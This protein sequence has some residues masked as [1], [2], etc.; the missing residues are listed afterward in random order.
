MNKK[1]TCLLHVETL[2]RID[3]GREGWENWNRN[4]ANYIAGGKKGGKL[5]GTRGN[6]GRIK[7]LG[8]VKNQRQHKENE[9]KEEDIRNTQI[10]IIQIHMYKDKYV[11]KD[12]NKNS[13]KE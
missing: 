12:R 6:N 1:N 5:R 7:G 10:Q 3:G 13:I 4:T 8:I 9:K 2:P 11:G